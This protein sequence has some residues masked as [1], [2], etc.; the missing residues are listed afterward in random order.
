MNLNFEP[1]NS[2]STEQTISRPVKVTD[3][4]G[5]PPAKNREEQEVLRKKKGRFP[6]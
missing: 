6:L 1:E 4:E 5:T 3:I 2:L